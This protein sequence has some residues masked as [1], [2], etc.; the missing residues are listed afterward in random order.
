MQQNKHIMKLFKNFHMPLYAAAAMI[1]LSLL[2][3]VSCQEESRP[4]DG[5]QELPVIEGDS[6]LATIEEGTLSKTAIGESGETSCTM[7]W[8]EDDRVSAFMQNTTLWQYVI[9]PEAAGSASA[10]FM[11]R[12][13]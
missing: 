9:E 6:F 11:M 4:G 2:S 8:S 5:Q 10:E 7:V 3:V 12:H 1:L 13:Q